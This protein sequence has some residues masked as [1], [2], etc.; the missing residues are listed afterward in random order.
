[1]NYFSSQSM[2]QQGACVSLRILATT[3]LHMHVFPYDYYTTTPSPGTGLGT[4]A[5]LIQHLR[6]E[7]ANSLLVDGG[8]LIQGNPLG[9]YVASCKDLRNGQL[10]PVIA[11]MNALKYDAMTLGNHDFNYGLPFLEATVAGADYPVVSANVIRRAGAS[12][13]CDQGLV[14]P[15]ALLDRCLTDKTGQAHPIRVGVIGLTPPQIVKWDRDHLRGSVV[16]RDITEAAKAHVPVMKE[17]GADIIIALCHSGIGEPAHDEMAENSAISVARVPGIDAM[18]LGHSHQVFPGRGFRDYGG[19]VDGMRGTICGKPA[20]MGGFWGSHVGVIDLALR[21]EAGEWRVVG[22]SSAARRVVRST[23]LRAAGPSVSKPLGLAGARPRAL[24]HPSAPNLLSEVRRMHREVIAHCRRPVGRLATRMTSYF[25]RVAPNEVVQLTADA[26]K[27]FV[28]RALAHTE[29]GELPLLS[30]TAPYKSGGRAGPDF[31]NDIPAGPLSL[32]HMSDMCLFPNQ[33]RAVRRTGAQ[34]QDWLERAAGQFR[35]IVPGGADQCLLDPEFPVYNFDCI[36]GLSYDIDLTQ[37]ARF[38]PFGTLLNPSASRIRNL[39][40]RGFPVRPRDEFVLATNNYRV[41][42]GGAFAG[43]ADHDV[44]FESRE[45]SRS[46]L[47]KYVRHLE[48]VEPRAHHAGWRFAPLPGTSCIFPTGTGARLSGCALP[49]GVSLFEAAR[50]AGQQD[51]YR[52][53][54]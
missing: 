22:H 20:V 23:E 8:D 51:V 3:D 4:A 21:P 29:L 30:A 2:E 35:T 50:E 10:H 26:Q 47:E 32:R 25:A 14:A 38:S 44:V 28:A 12:A 46:V 24:A 33:I 1:M 15:F 39:R 16:T 31:Y 6:G 42:G 27:W 45:L 18:V 49:D 17:A 48:M 52:I 54:L 53:S 19:L 37:P 40:H 9:D 7:V 13:R 41:S 36:D 5:R 34:L 11:A 43:V